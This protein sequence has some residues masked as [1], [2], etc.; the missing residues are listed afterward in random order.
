M[1]DIGIDKISKSN[2]DKLYFF[3][4]KNIG[5]VYDAN[6]FQV[7]VSNMKMFKNSFKVNCLSSGKLVLIYFIKSLRRSHI[8]I[9][10]NYCKFEIILRFHNKN[11]SNF[12]QC[13]FLFANTTNYFV[14]IAFSFIRSLTIFT[15]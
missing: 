11:L 9:K 7:M 8:N 14:N 15:F 10:D 4:K 2:S 6:I 12:Y 5:Y 3:T 13:R 1:R